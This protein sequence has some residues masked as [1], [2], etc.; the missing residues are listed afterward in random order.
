MY[1]D[2]AIDILL[3]AAEDK[4]LWGETY[5][6]AHDE[7][8]SVMEIAQE[9]VKVFGRGSVKQID[10]PDE[11]RRIEVD[12]VRISS[13]RIR[14]LTGWHAKLSFHEGLLKTKVILDGQSKQLANGGGRR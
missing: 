6:A 8:L 2:D 5:F 3:A 7:H 10:W 11:R 1:V 9:I 12:R 13:E 14:A 4:R